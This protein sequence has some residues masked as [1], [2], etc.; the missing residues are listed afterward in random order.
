MA[1]KWNTTKAHTPVCGVRGKKTSIGRRNVGV[2]S[3]NKNMKRSFKK[4]RGQG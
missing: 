4:Y 3:M 2:A 1:T